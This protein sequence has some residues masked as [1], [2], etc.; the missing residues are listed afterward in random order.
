MAALIRIKLHSGVPTTIDDRVFHLSHMWHIFLWITTLL[1]DISI[2]RG[3]LSLPTLHF[4]SWFSGFPSSQ[5][6]RALSI[7][8]HIYTHIPL[9]YDINAI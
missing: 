5:G 1:D 8:H 2:L 9:I 7:T 4:F 6:Y 3:I